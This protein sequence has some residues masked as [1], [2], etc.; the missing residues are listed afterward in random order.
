MCVPRERIEHEVGV[1]AAGSA[2]LED[3]QDDL[4]KDLTPLDK[5]PVAVERDDLGGRLVAKH[6]E[7]VV[8]AGESWKFND[9]LPVSGSFDG[10]WVLDL[11][12][13]RSFVSVIDAGGFTRASERVH[14]TQ[15]TVSQQILKLEARVG[16]P[17]LV[18]RA[19]GVVLTEHGE[20]LLGYARRIL[21]LATEAE[22]M[23]LR[24]GS[25]GTVRLGMHENLAG[26]LVASLLAEVARAHPRLRLDVECGLSVDLL[27]ALERGDLDVVLAIREPGAG[28]CVASWPR[29]LVWVAGAKSTSARK[30]PVPLVVFPQG[31]LYRN[32]AIHAI[33]AQGR[34]WRIAFTSPSLAS[35]QAAVACGLGVSILPRRAVASEHRILG[36]KDGFPSIPNT[37]LALLTNPAPTP[38]A[39]L[40]ARYLATVVGAGA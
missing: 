20:R 23:L 37:E 10:D 32:R 13:L 40:L 35:V 1:R 31:C 3:G 2:T 9:T 18:R 39:T 28:P 29:R 22:D 5:G 12:L 7:S 8:L 36:A 6:A 38:H 15:S 17:L 24:S 27:R 11:A 14:R 16:E 30:E 33:E 25:E 34:R 4:M 21:S 19:R 26:A